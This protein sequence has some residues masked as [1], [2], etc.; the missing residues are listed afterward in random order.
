MNTLEKNSIDELKK[1]PTALQ[2][3]SVPLTE[4]EQDNHISC[5]KCRWEASDLFILAHS[6]EEANERYKKDPDSAQCS[7]C[8]VYNE[9]TSTEKEYILIATK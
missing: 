2:V 7:D 8:L 5:P 9:L 3:F 4:E 6:Q 1:M